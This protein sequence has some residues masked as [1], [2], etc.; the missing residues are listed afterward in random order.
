MPTRAASDL[1][2]FPAGMNGDDPAGQAGETY[3]L[4]PGPFDHRG[5]VLGVGKLLDRFDQIA[6]G[7]G[8]A[9]DEP[10]DQRNH[11]EGVGFIDFGEQGRLDM[12]KFEAQEATAALERTVGFGQ[13]LFVAGIRCELPS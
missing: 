12:G 5:E 11:G 4:E 3:P 8:L 1:L 9:G 10:A 7:L 2:K 13:G 6:I